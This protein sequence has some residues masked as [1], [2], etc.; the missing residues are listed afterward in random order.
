MSRGLSRSTTTCSHLAQMTHVPHFTSPTQSLSPAQHQITRHPGGQ[1]VSTASHYI[2]SGDH[3]GGSVRS[4]EFEQGGI[5]R[6]RELFHGASS[7]SKEL[8][9][10]GTSRSR[11]FESGG[12]FRSKTPIRTRVT[13]IIESSGVRKCLTPPPNMKHYPSVT[14]SQ[15]SPPNTAPLPKK[16]RSRLKHLLERNP[17]LEFI[18]CTFFRY[19]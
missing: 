17:L 6:S 16:I 18:S 5:S 12:V 14:P 15:P 1:Y 2:S 11:E 3:H 4:R 13:A 8:E 9:Q 7:R 19:I 10:R